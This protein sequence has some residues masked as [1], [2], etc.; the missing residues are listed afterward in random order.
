MSGCLNEMNQ[1]KLSLIYSPENNDKDVHFSTV[2]GM[3]AY[4]FSER[5][6]HHRRFS[7]KVLQKVIF[8]KD[9]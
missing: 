9:R 5:D 6:S 7:M 8:T 2:T 4:S 3:W 1:K